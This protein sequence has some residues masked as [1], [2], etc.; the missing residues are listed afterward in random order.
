VPWVEVLGVFIVCHLAGDYLLQTDWQ[1]TNKHGGLGSD[2]E[3]RR[4]LVT[5]GATYTLAYVPALIWLAGDLGAAVL[6][7]AAVIAVTHVIQDDGRLI[8]AYV[9]TVKRGELRPGP[10]LMAV[11]QSFHVLALFLVA[12]VAGE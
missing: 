9:R 8:G 4:A 7:V 1:A 12:L 10:T 2:R 5:H 3:A 6:A 11:D